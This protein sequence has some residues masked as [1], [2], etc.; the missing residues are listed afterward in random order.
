M[1]L[2]NQKG[3]YETTVQRHLGF[4]DQLISDKKDLSEKVG[5]IRPTDLLGFIVCNYTIGT[6]IS[7][8]N[9]D[10]GGKFISLSPFLL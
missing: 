1:R 2:A 4:I 9:L 10:S 8:K 3:Q 6:N 5:K 7:D